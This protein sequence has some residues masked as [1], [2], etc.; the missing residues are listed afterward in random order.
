V[1]F[2]TGCSVPAGFGAGD[3][4]TGATLVQLQIASATAV[5]SSKRTRDPI[6]S[7]LLVLDFA[8]KQVMRVDTLLGCVVEWKGIVKTTKSPNSRFFGFCA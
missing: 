8:C 5:P 1:D 7:R 3:G 2:G 4:A 6:R